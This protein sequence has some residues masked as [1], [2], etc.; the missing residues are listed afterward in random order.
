MCFADFVNQLLIWSTYHL[1]LYIS[2]SA[3]LPIWTHLARSWLV[4]LKSI[5]LIFES[6]VVQMTLSL[7]ELLHSSPKLRSFANFLKSVVNESTFS[8]LNCSWKNTPI[9]SFI[10]WWKNV[11]QVHSKSH[12]SISYLNQKYI[13]CYKPYLLPTVKYKTAT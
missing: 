5:F 4:S 10:I 1:S 7:N 6:P 12:Y 9:N 2:S 13:M 11:F 8:H 3:A